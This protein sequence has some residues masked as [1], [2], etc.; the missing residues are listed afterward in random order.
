MLK[1]KFVF[2]FTL[3]FSIILTIL[4]YFTPLELSNDEDI[5]AQIDS[6]FL[7]LFTNNLSACV[8]AVIIGSVSLGL[9]SLFYLFVNFFSIGMILSTLNVK[10]SIMESLSTFVIH[11]VFEIPAMLLS[12]SLGIYIPLKF[13][14][15]IRKK[16]WDKKEMLKILWV[17]SSILLLT[18]IAAFIEAYI[19][20]IFIK[21]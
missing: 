17:F 2:I 11:G 19:S 7:Y 15:F 3:L 1:F 14:Q 10:H 13:I 12:A 16:R 6:T 5:D 4:G 9:Y 8:Y 18:L 20:P 21:M